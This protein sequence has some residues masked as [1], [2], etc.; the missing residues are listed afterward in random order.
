[1]MPVK[2]GLLLLL[3]AVTAAAATTARKNVVYFL[4]DD[5]RPN[6][7]PYFN[8]T[9]MH[10]PHLQRLADTGAVFERAYC[11]QAVCA[12]SRLSVTTGRTPSTLRAWN[13]VNHWRQAS[14]AGSR[15]N[16]MRVADGVPLAGAGWT[17][18]GKPLSSGGVAQCCTTCAG[19]DGCAGWTYDQANRGA[20]CALYASVA[21][22]EPC[23]PASLRAGL[24][25][26]SGGRGA[27]PAVTPL[28]QLFKNHGYTTLGVGKIYHDG[29]RGK[30]VP[31]SFADAADYPAGAGLPPMADAGL[32]WSNSSVQ[33][34]DIAAY[35]KEW[36]AFGNTYG[37]TNG[38]SYLAPDD[39]VCG[40]GVPGNNTQGHAPFCNPDVPLDGSGAGAFGAALCDY[41]TYNDAKTK[42]R[43][44]AS[45]LRGPTRAPFFLAVGIRRPHLQWR[46]P[47]GYAALYPPGAVDAPKRL[48]LDASV[49]P[50]A[51][52]PFPIFAG[53]PRQGATPLGEGP[54]ALA[55]ASRAAAAAADADVVELRRHYY[56]AISWAD[57]ACGQVLAELDALGLANETLVV[58]HS[59]HGWHLGEWN[60]YEKRTM[61]ELGTR[62]PLFVRAPWLGAA[63]AGSRFRELV[64]LVDVYPTVAELAGVPL[65]TGESYPFD[66]RSLAPLLAGA[67]PGHQGGQQAYAPRA[68]ALQVFPR[69][70]T[71]GDPAWGPTA[72]PQNTCLDVERSAFSLMGFA[73]RTDRYRYTEWRRWNGTALR[74]ESWA[75]AP[76]AREL[77][78]H[79]GD[80][81]PWT[82]PGRFEAR[83]EA[84]TAPAALVSALSAQL[85]ALVAAHG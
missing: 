1:M 57:Y 65:P 69:C 62:V 35:R 17:D 6:L 37:Q 29:G 55:N 85:R 52:S 40:A 12:P 56:A 68:A 13:F 78:D 33:F 60:Q 43:Y 51:Y 79:L 11:N 53:G 27:F 73:M 36:G 48:A 42:L 84:A 28:P 16:R 49:N 34:P 76:Y 26:V 10:T 14:C 72:W 5:L 70:L 32:S 75:D 61:W 30:G 63:H 23:A 54:E 44:A 74:A 82:D 22:L 45:V 4:F 24:A 15:A 67:A 81:A 80:D 41:V 50:V 18:K 25:C 39:E 77:Y 9:T 3:L 20:T 19:T 8:T 59:D 46:A 7:S 71:A 58:A 47:A 64:E 38:Y 31:A 83:N 2:I 21:R 66:G